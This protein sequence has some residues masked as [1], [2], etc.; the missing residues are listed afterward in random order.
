M[1]RRALVLAALLLLAWAPVA[2]AQAGSVTVTSADV[3]GGV[4]QYTLAWVS[5]AGGAVSGNTIAIKRGEILAVKFRPD[6]GGTAPTDLYDVTFEDPDNV[7]LLLGGG[8][9][10]SGTLAT[11]KKPALNT[12]DSLFFE[13]SASCELVVANAGAARGGTVIL[14]VGR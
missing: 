2:H 13:G 5:S 8:A 6:G 7:D 11:R 4:T 1:G 10:L 3:G 14:L 9:N 12:S